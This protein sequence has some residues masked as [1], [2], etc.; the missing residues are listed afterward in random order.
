MR[1]SNSNFKLGRL[2]L[3]AKT[4]S[5]NCAKRFRTAVE[6]LDACSRVNHTRL[7]NTDTHATLSAWQGVR[8]AHFRA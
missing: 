7:R 4:N 6:L 3:S 5:T 8:A 1:Y 2:A